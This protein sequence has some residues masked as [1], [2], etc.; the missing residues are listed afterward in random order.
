MGAGKDRVDICQLGSHSLA[1]GTLRG[2]EAVEAA[3]KYGLQLGPSRLRT[4][5]MH[6]RLRQGHS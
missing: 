4:G 6:D 5:V 1:R 3:V 2:C